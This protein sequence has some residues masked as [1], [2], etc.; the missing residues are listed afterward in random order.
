MKTRNLGARVEELERENGLLR[1]ALH[2]NDIPPTPETWAMHAPQ[3][4]RDQMAASALIAERLDEPRALIRLGF[5]CGKNTTN[6]WL[7]EVW[8]T[9]KKVFGT[10]GVRAIL[11][12]D[13]EDA[14]A[15]KAKIIAR[16]VQTSMH[17]SDGDSVRAAQQLA[18]MADW[19]NADK[20]ALPT[21][22]NINLMQMYGEG[23][24]K[25]VDSTVSDVE[26]DGVIDAEHFLL[27]EPGEATLISDDET[28]ALHK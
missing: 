16:L 19:N 3:E 20:G 24:R 7:P 12:R 5:H 26:P 15:N 13:M 4:L 8:E 6:R 1:D 2:L 14:E 23:S 21:N 22:V 9:A 11:E 10:P 18:K 27:H 28:T 17:G 25:A